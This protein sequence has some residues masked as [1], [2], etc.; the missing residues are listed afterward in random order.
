[1]CCRKLSIQTSLLVGSR[2]GS[3]LLQRC[4]QL[5]EDFLGLLTGDFSRS[6]ILS[7]PLRH[8]RRFVVRETGFRMRLDLRR[9]GRR[10]EGRGGRGWWG[11]GVGHDRN[12]FLGYVGTL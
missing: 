3:A 10:R 12:S 7:R 8:G 11:G 4:V 2:I 1:F 9:D 6:H 5:V